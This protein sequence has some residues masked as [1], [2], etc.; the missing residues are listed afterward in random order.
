[1]PLVPALM[2]HAIAWARARETQPVQLL[3][4]QVFL[5]QVPS[6]L[7]LHDP[8]SQLRSQV[9]PALQVC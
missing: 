8:P 9:A 6:Q 5:L 4:R 2:A 1:M 3:P 7:R